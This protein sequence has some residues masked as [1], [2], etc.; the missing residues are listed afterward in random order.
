[1]QVKITRLMLDNNALFLAL[2]LSNISIYN[3]ILLYI[4]KLSS[5]QVSIIITKIKYWNL[6]SS[7]VSR[8]TL[9]IE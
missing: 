6:K 5:N 7:D 8:G 9:N 1:M 4:T 3:K 2:L